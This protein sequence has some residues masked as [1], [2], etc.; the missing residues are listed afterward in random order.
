MEKSNSLGKVLI[1]FLSVLVV[2]STTVFGQLTGTKTVGGGSPDYATI[3]AAITALNSSGVGSGGVTFNVAAGHTETVSSLANYKITATGTASNPIVFQ[4]SGVGVNP[5]ISTAAAGNGTVAGTSNTTS[6]GDGIIKLVGTD[7]ITFDGIDLTEGYTGTTT[8]LLVESGYLLVRQSSTNGCQNVTIRNCVVTLKNGAVLYT[9][10][11][12]AV[13]LNDAGTTTA[14]TSVAGGFRDITIDGC[15]IINAGCGIMFYGN[16]TT[17]YYDQGINIGTSQGNTIENFGSNT[18]TYG[19]HTIYQNEVSIRKNTISNLASASSA[20]YGIYSNTATNAN[21]T[22]DSNSIT[23]NRTVAGSTTYGI[24]NGGGSSGTN[25]TVNITNNNVSNWTWTVPTSSTLYYIYSSASPYNLN[26]SNNIIQNNSYGS[27]SS[28]ATGTN[29]CLYMTGGAASNNSWIINNN[30]ISGNTRNQSTL[31]TGTSAGIFV[32]SS[33]TNLTI[34]DNFI[35]GNTF[36]GSTSSMYGLNITSSSTNCDVYNNRIENNSIYQTSGTYYGLN[37]TGSPINLNIYNNL[38]NNETKTATGGTTYGLYT[39]GANSTS[40]IHT[41][42][43]NKVKG[44]SSTGSTTTY[45]IFLN[46][47]TSGTI[48]RTYQDTIE[49]LSTTGTIYGAYFSTYDSLRF[50]K[51]FIRNLTTTSGSVNGIYCIGSSGLRH[52]FVYNNIIS[53]LTATTSSS[54][55]GVTGMYFS[56]G[57][58]IGAYFN[59]IFLSATSSS[60][61]FGSAGIFAGSSPG[62]LEFI[63]N[64]VINNS[65]PGSGNANAVTAGYWRSAGGSLANHGSSSNSNN[66]YGG[67]G[68]PYNFVYFDQFTAN[69]DQTIAGF[70]TRV[71]G[72]SGSFSSLPPFLNSTSAP[73]DL[74]I[75]NSIATQAESG[76]LA[77]TNPTGVV[78]DFFGNARYGDV[79]YSGNGTAPDVGAHEDDFVGLDLT[80]PGISFTNLG[81]APVT[82]SREILD[83]VVTDASGVDSLNRPR[84]YFKKSSEPN[85]LATANDS[86]YTGWKYVVAIGTGASPY[87]FTI[88]HQL[89]NAY[90]SLAIGD[91]IQY[92]VVAQDLAPTANVGIQSG[93]FAINPSSVVLASTAFPIGGTLKSYQFSP[94][95]SGTYTIGSGGDY[96]TLTG[97]GGLFEDINSKTVIGNITAKILENIPEPATNGINQWSEFGGSGYTLT[98]QPADTVGSEIVISGNYSGGLIRFN[99]ADGVIIDGRKNES[100]KWLRFVNSNASGNVFHFSTDAENDTIRFAIIQGR[101]TSSTSGNI[102]FGSATNA[103]SGNYIGYCDIGDDAGNLPLYSIYSASNRNSN[104]RIEFNNIYNF[105]SAGVR[106]QTSGASSGAGDGWAIESNRFY[107]TASRTSVLYPIWL[108]SGAGHNINNN[109][110]GGSDS[111]RVGTATVTSNTFYGIYL[112]SSGTNANTINHNTISN[113]NSSSFYGIYLNGGDVNLRGNIIG[114]LTLV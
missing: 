114:G 86:N 111:S 88:N 110:I 23:F 95:M 82:S 2:N 58:N 13:N 15:T 90:S 17:P 48:I 92:F 50:Y 14:P 80:S 104:N 79:G 72:E 64:L 75:N 20:I 97:T 100:G 101:N 85:S 60:T 112:Q 66:Y 91:I 11:I 113:I 16:S 3:A 38:I 41:V 68:S 25:N 77:I 84:L 51:N 63:N 45:G 34:N 103:N 27:G 26:C 108:Q 43:N 6:N 61:S 105:S 47:A 52:T 5:K 73:Y 98:I 57:G 83:V 56:N 40:A 9:M 71:G 12:R 93:S 107:Q 36:R 31:G 7:Y 10:G 102:Y 28:T 74:R 1:L 78:G 8:S 42:Y 106:W 21:I 55:P 37:R 4:K 69:G 32:S 87:T 19:I 96:P 65:T 22:I 94:T 33:S 30:T 67:T 53:E 59:T 39:S 44:I 70:K 99:G 49:D 76:G 29:Y 109:S 24:I 35:T 18:T 46:G 89:L 62:N 54:A 81:N